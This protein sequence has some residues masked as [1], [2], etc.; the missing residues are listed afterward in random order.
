MKTTHFYFFQKSNEIFHISFLTQDAYKQQVQ[1][2]EN[3]IDEA[4]A[5]YLND[6]EGQIQNQNFT[7]DD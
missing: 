3:Y 2:P 1:V 6:V 5:D 7:S 4:Y